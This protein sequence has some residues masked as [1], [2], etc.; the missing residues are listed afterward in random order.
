MFQICDSDLKIISICAKFGGA[1]HDS[2]VWRLWS[3]SRYLEEEHFNNGMIGWLL[4]D[5]GYPQRPWLMTPVLHTT[6][7]TPQ[8]HYTNMHV[9]TRVCVERCIGLLKARWRCLLRHRVLHYEPTKCAK[10]INACAVLHNLCLNDGIVIEDD[11]DD[12]D[13]SPN[14]NDDNM[15]LMD[16][17]LDNARQQLINILWQNPTDG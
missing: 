13:P 10:I 15:I 4:G 3:I 17:I 1:A 5:S 11:D 12:D 16:P 9:H 2:Y 7:N 8:A 6:E 14:Y